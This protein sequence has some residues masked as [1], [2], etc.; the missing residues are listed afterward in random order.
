MKPLG[1][2]LI[3]GGASGLG[4]ATVAAVREAGGRPL[5]LDRVA[6]AEGVEHVLVDLADTDTTERAVTELVDR[7]GGRL[8]GV[9][10]AAGI[11][12]CGPLTE[13]PAKDWERVVH[14]NLLGTAAV[15]RA[16]LPH[17][18][19]TH[20]T[21]VTVASTLG[22]KAVSDAT[23]YCASKYGVVG[24]TKALAA[25]TAGRV[26]V[27]LL[28]PGGMHTNFFNDR[29]EQYK[30]PADAKLN[31]P[32]DVARTVLFAL[33]QPPGCEVRELVVCASEEGSYP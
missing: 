31:H 22:I 16:A 2:V 1:N 23:A 3:T 27:T 24:F 33:R 10:T 9:F 29:P 17:L 32:E 18:E 14:V 19:R 21:V 4:A 15:V 20:G 30:P 7:A 11:D 5:V 12:A 6:P 13:V 28:V 26:G 8:D 25:E